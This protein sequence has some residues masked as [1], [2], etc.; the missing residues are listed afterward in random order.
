VDWSLGMHAE[1]LVE[2]CPLNCVS[3]IQQ[4]FTE[5]MDSWFLVAV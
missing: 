1:E 2:V 4:K 3:V 5:T